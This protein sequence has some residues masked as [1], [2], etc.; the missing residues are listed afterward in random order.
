M[1]KPLY[2]SLIL[3]L[4]A[5]SLY[6]VGAGSSAVSTLLIP[7]SSRI[8]ALGETCTPLENDITLL[9]C[10]PAGIYGLTG[11]NTSLMYQRGYA[12][13]NYMNLHIGKDYKSLVLATSI[14]YYSTGEI[15]LYKS[16]GTL[17]KEVGKR[18]IVWTLGASKKIWRMPVGVNLKLISSE[19][20][21]ETA[22][23][24]ALDMGTQYLINDKLNLGLSVRNLGT[25]IK[26]LSEEE[27]LP[28]I[29]QFGSSYIK[30]FNKYRLLI[31]DD[32]AYYLNEEEY[33]NMTGV[34]LGYQERYFLRAG[35]KINLSETEN[36]SFS[37][38]LGFICN[39]ITV[40]YSIEM[41]NSLNIPHRV[42]LG[43]IY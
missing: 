2:L 16:N 35:Y 18:E 17:V 1:R 26:Y 12:E 4:S 23:A 10:N 20:F 29:V 41:N 22:S 8:S 5:T 30:E 19:L 3:I 38:G 9:N 27:S 24:Y 14:L 36:Q 39:K 33:L 32:V 13:D 28:T 11:W 15:E 7:V 40:D 31:L 21:G 34:E 37:V 25:K 43:Y 42:S 6:A